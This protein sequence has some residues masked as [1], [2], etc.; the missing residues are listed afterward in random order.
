M[1]IKL[2]VPDGTSTGTG[3]DK[4]RPCCGAGTWGLGVP[5]G[6]STGNGWGKARHCCGAGAG[7]WGLARGHAMALEWDLSAGGTYDLGRDQDRPLD[8][9]LGTGQ[10][11]GCSAPSLLTTGRSA[12]TGTTSIGG[13]EAL[14]MARRGHGTT[15]HSPKVLFFK[16]LTSLVRLPGAGTCILLDAGSATRGSN[17]RLPTHQA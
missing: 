8:W 16:N 3:W 5:D 6:T 10:T 11:G 12:S 15:L 1:G 9:D 17:C 4:A 2:G 7:T 13:A 14:T